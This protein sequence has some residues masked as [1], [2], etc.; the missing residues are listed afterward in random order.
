MAQTKVYSIKIDGVDQAVNNINDLENGV[1]TLDEKLKGAQIGSDEFNR[2]SKEVSKAK[3]QLKDFELQVEGLDKEQ[4][5]TALVDTFNGLAGGVGAV[6]SA[7]IAFGAESG[8]I[9]EA[10]KKLL[11]VIG[12]VSGLKE[13]SNGVLQAQKLL[14]A[15]NITLGKSFTAAFKAGTNGTKALKVGL[16]STGIGALIVAVGLLITYWEDLV[17]VIGLGASEGEKNLEIAEAQTAEAEKALALTNSSTE[18]LK[19]Q[20][21][22]DEEIL[23]LKIAQTKEVIK[24]LQAQLIAQETIKKEQI[25]SAQRNKEI[26]QGILQFLTAPI[27]VLLKAIDSVGKAL[28]KDFGLVDKTYSAIAGLAFDPEKVAEDADETIATTE[29]KLLELQNSVA[30]FENKK[31]GD[32]KRRRDERKKAN[33]AEAD[34]EAKALEQ[35]QADELKAIEDAEKAK[36]DLKLAQQ[37]DTLDKLKVG[38]ENQLEDLRIAQEKE[39]AN[40]TLTEEARKAI[41]DKFDTERLLALETYNDAVVEENIATAQEIADAK[42][43]ADAKQLEIDEKKKADDDQ[44]YSDRVALAND[45]FNAIIAL[46]DAFGGESEEQQKKAFNIAKKAQIAQAT[47]NGILAV[48]NAFATASA[49]PLTAIFPAYPFIQAGLA[50]A[51]ALANIKKISSQQFQSANAGGVDSGGGGGGAQPSVPGGTSSGSLGAPRPTQDQNNSG[52]NRQK[53]E[54]QQPAIRT[55]VLAGD[56]SS[57]Q[58]AEQK[59]NQRRTL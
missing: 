42:A 7:F 29:A 19:Q 52:T 34:E 17:N 51:F 47:I 4:R 22:T 11:G 1:R 24:S 59:I 57:A 15:S 36:R 44:I 54:S 10:E 8:A 23:D 9:E 41:R 26:L 50:G 2:L 30:G 12:V 14:A 3:S 55:Y 48:Q 56:V 31:A 35:Q 21:M 32:A 38:Y 28:G 33:Q 27:A 25:A 46:A 5:A 13:A 53:P 49:S 18:L 45:S 6:S 43:E 39:L 20:G 58:N 16:V 37:K 40:E